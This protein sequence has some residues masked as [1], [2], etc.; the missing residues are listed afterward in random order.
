MA[1]V[2]PRGSQTVHSAALALLGSYIASSFAL[3]SDIHGGTLV[4]TEASQM[5][6]QSVL[7]NPHHA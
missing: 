5:V 2:V 4:V 1:L 7:V 6:G 3:E